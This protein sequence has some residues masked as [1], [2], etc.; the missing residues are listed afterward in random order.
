MIDLLRQRN[1]GLEINSVFDNVFSHYGKIINGYNFSEGLR[2]MEKRNIP[3]SGNV[4]VASDEELMGTAIAGDLSRTFYGNMPI[5]AGYCNG[6][7][8]RLNALEYHKC[9]EIDV[10]VTNLVLILGDIRNIKNNRFLSSSTEIFYVPAGTAIEL[11]GTTLHF[12]PCKVTGEGFKC[13]I[14]LPQGTNQP[15]IPLPSPKNEEDKLLWMQNKWLIAHPCSIP[16][17]KG[18]FAGIIGDNI[19]IKIKNEKEVI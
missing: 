7:T 4:Y 15:L 16:A 11:F 19:E 12:A 1:P 6:T 14:V 5:Q 2:I 18:A 3:E 17:A 10:A 9:S 8:S 13:I